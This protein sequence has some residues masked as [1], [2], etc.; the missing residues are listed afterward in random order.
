MTEGEGVKQFAFVARN[1]LLRSPND[2]ESKNHLI[3]AFYTTF[4][5]QSDHDK[6]SEFL[7]TFFNGITIPRDHK[8][9]INGENHGPMW[10]EAIIAE[11]DALV[12]NS[13]WE[14]H[15]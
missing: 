14:E 10:K 3:Q 4:T 9:A 12:T 6:E 2:R 13:I 11:I 15:I 8:I 7:E 1:I 5:C